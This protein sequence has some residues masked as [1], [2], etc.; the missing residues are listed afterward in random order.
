MAI[1]KALEAPFLLG[2]RLLLLDLFAIDQ[3]DQRHANDDKNAENGND[4]V[5]L[6]FRPHHSGVGA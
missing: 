3:G 2:E 6:Q 4:R 1:K 5:D